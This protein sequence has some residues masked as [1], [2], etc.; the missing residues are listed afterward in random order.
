MSALPV[1]DIAGQVLTAPLAAGKI[2]EE[3]AH[4]IVDIPVN[5]AAQVAAT[6]ANVAENAGETALNVAAD[7]KN[8]ALDLLN[9]ALDMKPGV[10]HAFS[11]P[12]SI[13]GGLLPGKILLPL[14]GD[15][16]TPQK[17]SIIYVV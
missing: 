2:A 15:T 4:G 5:T 8:G 11:S 9:S 14:D 7:M 6:A 16:E 17:R 10:L 12:L 3:V 13:I 1:L